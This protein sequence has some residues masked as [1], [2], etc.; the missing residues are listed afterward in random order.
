M[1]TAPEYTF[2]PGLTLKIIRSSFESPVKSYA[3]ISDTVN[4]CLLGYGEC[5]LD[6][7]LFNS[8]LVI[9]ETFTF[10]LVGTLVVP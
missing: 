2:A 3:S 9:S 5:S 6:L 1:P 8:L 7:K 10:N 4:I